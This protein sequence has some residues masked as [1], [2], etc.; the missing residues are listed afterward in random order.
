M[1]LDEFMYGIDG[2]VAEEVSKREARD[3]HRFWG[4]GPSGDVDSPAVEVALG[5]GA[6]A[7]AAS[8][9]A[10]FSAVSKVLWWSLSMSQVG[11]GVRDDIVLAHFAA[12]LSSSRC[13]SWYSRVSNGAWMFSTGSQVLS[14]SGYLLHSRLGT[15]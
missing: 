7:A 13:A 8:L 2:R 6:V 10:T 11:W 4:G 1:E 15:R 12:L 3:V 14:L 9:A 5:V